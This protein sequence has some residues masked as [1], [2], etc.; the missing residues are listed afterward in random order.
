MSWYIDQG[1]DSDVFVSSR[2]RLA[3]NLDRMPFPHRM[4]SQQ[5]REAAN[6]IVG[7]FYQDDANRRHDYLMI[8][9]ETLSDQDR[10]ALAEKRLISDDLARKGHQHR[11]II[12][13]DESV[14][15]MINE[16]DHIRIQS[17]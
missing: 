4:D 3:R 14:S 12:S 17:I 8:D 13:R 5:A 2:I 10:Q 6:S 7:S 15:I 1:P 9:L 16:E 11:V